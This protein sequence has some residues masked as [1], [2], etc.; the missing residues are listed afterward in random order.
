MT[1]RLLDQAVARATGESLATIRK[2]GFGL[3]SRED[4]TDE[5]QPA[6][7]AEAQEAPHVSAA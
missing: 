4:D 1:Q 6:P 3:A 7:A 5:P 2:R